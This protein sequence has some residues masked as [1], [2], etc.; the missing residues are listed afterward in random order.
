MNKIITIFFLITFFSACSSGPKVKQ[1]EYATLN[2]E[3]EF[4]EDYDKVWKAILAATNELKAEKI[5][6]DN[7]TYI[8][9]WANTTSTDK[10]YEFTVNGLPRKHYLQTRYKYKITAEKLLGRV[11][12]TVL[13][14]EQ[15]EKVKADGSF[16]DWKNTENPDSSRAAAM[17]DKIQNKMLS[18]HL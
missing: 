3:R 8:S 12:V 13:Q 6:K 9:D 10:Y 17:L 4:E 1:Q 14:W 5:E 11:K 7:G 16:D 2:H 18:A 15:I